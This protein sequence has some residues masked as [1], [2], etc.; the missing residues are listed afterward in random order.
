VQVGDTVLVRKEKKG[1]L[2]ANFSNEKQEVVA[3]EGSEVVV[4]DE[5]KCVRRNSTFVKVVPAASL[6][7]TS[8]SNQ[9]KT[10]CQQRNLQRLVL[11]YEVINHQID[12]M[13]M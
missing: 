12:T 4:R 2:D 9:V 13:I 7:S 11:Q 8:Q 3:K 10:C 5:G 6:E 1:K